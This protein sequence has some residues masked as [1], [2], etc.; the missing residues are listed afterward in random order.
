MTPLLINFLSIAL[1]SLI[2]V[3]GVWITA[4]YL[5]RSNRERN[6]NDRDIAE[7]TNDQNAF[8]VVT[9][10][11][12]RLNDGIR[13]EMDELRKKV[14]ALEGLVTEKNERIQGLESEIE[15][16]NLALRHQVDVGRQLANYIRRLITFWP[17]DAGPPPAPEP[18]FDWE[19]HLT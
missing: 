7:E 6:Q 1:P 10:Q 19:R 13:L 12:F 15:E 4:A 11:L 2:A 5:R 16:T 17:T 14:V 3:G 8:K 9:D 18:A